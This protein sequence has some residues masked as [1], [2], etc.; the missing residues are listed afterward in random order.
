MEH[1]T[2]PFPYWVS[3]NALQTEMAHGIFYELT[4]L[5]PT[6]KW[7]KYDNVFERKYANDKLEE[8]PIKTKTFLEICNSKDFVSSIERLTGIEN[9]VTDH[10]Y[11][12]GGI[13]L[14]GYD[15]KLDLHKDFSKHPS[16][17]LIRRLNVLIYFNKNWE[18]SWGGELELWS[19]DM[20]KCE[21]KIEPIFNRMVIF[22]TPD[23][24]HGHPNPWKAPNSIYRKSLALYY[25]KAPTIEDLQKEHLSTQFLKKP[26]EQTTPEIEALRE[27]RN[28]G[29]LSSNV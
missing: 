8:M 4:K 3:D 10:T 12:G 29:R 1:G 18:P 9:L 21:V 15:G 7:Y 19:K 27:K 13:H 6:D 14:I 23:A 26:D 16:L 2:S 24:P 25:Y 5:E 28:K 20:S 17:G 22:E 11:R